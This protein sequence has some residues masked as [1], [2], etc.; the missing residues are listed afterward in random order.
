MNDA[1][2]IWPVKMRVSLIETESHQ[3]MYRV[4]LKVD[5]IECE[6]NEAGEAFFLDEAIA[7]ACRALRI[8]VAR[9]EKTPDG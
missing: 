9:N 2:K 8:R 7:I 4:T 6:I 5:A 3:L 1:P